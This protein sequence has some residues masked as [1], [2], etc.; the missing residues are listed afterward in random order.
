R[1]PLPVLLTH[2]ERLDVEGGIRVGPARAALAG[3]GAGHRG[4]PRGAALV[5]GLAAGQLGR[6][7]PLPGLLVHDERLEQVGTV[8]IGPT[9]TALA[10]RGARYGGDLCRATLVQ[11]GG[12]WYLDRLA[13]PAVCLVHDEGL[14]VARTVGVRAASPAV[15]HGTA[16]HRRNLRRPAEV[17]S[18]GPR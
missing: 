10:R 4:D 9:G 8:R 11:H 6:G 13:P 7:A 17:Q 2:D 18:G 3:L 15:A 14:D 5:E 12:R 1:A 16:R